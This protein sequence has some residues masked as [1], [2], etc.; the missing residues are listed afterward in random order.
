MVKSPSAL[1]VHSHSAWKVFITCKYKTSYDWHYR[2][3]SIVLHTY[4]D[5]TSILMA[6]YNINR[7]TKNFHVKT[8]IVYT[9]HHVQKVGTLPLSNFK[10]LLSPTEMASAMKLLDVGPYKI[11]T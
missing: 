3:T 10:D 7:L 4:D 11:K 2:V 1:V 5:M 9:L 8:N 6:M